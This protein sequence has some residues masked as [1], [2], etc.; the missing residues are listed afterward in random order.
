M[1]SKNL[2]TSFQTMAIATESTKM[3]HCHGFSLL[4]KKLTYVHKSGAKDQSHAN[5]VCSWV[6]IQQQCTKL[7]SLERE[8]KCI[9]A[10]STHR[11]CTV[12]DVYM[13]AN[14]EGRN[15]KGSVTWSLFIRFL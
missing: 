14:I 7:M 4:K 6:C 2:A 5:L 9:A 1:T 8:T 3:S 11:I 12:L 15:G 13:V 10:N